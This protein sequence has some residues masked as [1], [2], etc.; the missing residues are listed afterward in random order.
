VGDHR[1][2]NNTEKEKDAIYSQLTNDSDEDSFCNYNGDELLEPFT[3]RSAIIP[4][5]DDD[6][7]R[8]GDHVYV[9]KSFGVLGSYQKHGIVLSAARTTDTAHEE[10][11]DEVSIVTFYHRTKRDFSTRDELYKT[12]Y[13]KEEND[14][15]VDCGESLI[16]AND[17][18]VTTTKPSSNNKKHVK[19]TATVR[20]ESLSTFLSDSTSGK[21]Q[22]VKYNQTLR[23][24]LLKRPGTVTACRADE[25][26]LIL[27]RVHY[28]LSAKSKLPE[29]HLV[30]ANGEC[31]AV[32]CRMG[33]WCTLQ[34]SSI[35]HILFAGQAGGAVV[36]G[37]A[38]SNMMVLTA[39]PGW[40]GAMGY[41]WYVPATVAY[42]I[43]TPLLIGF[44]LTSLVPLEVLR[45]FRKKWSS[46]THDINRNFWSQTTSDIK[47]Y[48][49]VSTSGDEDNTKSFFGIR[50]D[51]K[52]ND[53][54]VEEDR[55]DYL[56]LDMT[57]DDDID[58]EEEIEKKIT[59]EYGSLDPISLFDKDK[60]QDENK[61]EKWHNMVD[62]LKASFVQQKKKNTV[63]AV[64]DATE[65]SH[66][67]PLFE[68]DSV[69][70]II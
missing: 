49:Y 47:D 15:D 4:K 14:D 60:Q 9:W 61:N 43:L 46:I 30:A 27:A 12:Q 37:V 63:T 62:R 21:L 6:E 1:T 38:A 67:Q 29:H 52:D 10:D 34:G 25:R 20:I 50:S 69:R 68:K 39:A 33:R 58:A 19:R 42:P 16:T 22:K 65:E 24:R 57:G 64:E 18:T 26:P 66:Q 11:D 28:L 55:G 3:D 8:A 48:Y 35:L 40:W 53:T 41:V 54:K 70:E 17:N 2:A 7:L 31:A 44:G 23:K 51:Y 59:S 45:R 32:W 13:S 56:P 5:D 36:G